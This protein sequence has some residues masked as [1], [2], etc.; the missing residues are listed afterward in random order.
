MLPCQ[1]RNPAWILVVLLLVA[2]SAKGAAQEGSGETSLFVVDVELQS[3]E[4]FALLLDRAEQ[5]LIDGDAPQPDAA[6]VTFVL[7]GPVVR[8]LLREN[9]LTNKPLVDKAASLS[10]LGVIDIKACSTWMGANKVVEQ[11][12]Q[13][14]V[15]T[16]TYGAA[17]VQRL[18]EE[19]DY[20]YF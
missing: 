16:V 8:N 12:L 2:W 3:A 9:Y 13:P 17:E 6:A 7:H 18:L 10:A 20:V 14:F 15:G 1:P 11:D 5:L 19:E 4:E